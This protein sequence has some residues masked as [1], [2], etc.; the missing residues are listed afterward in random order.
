MAPFK[1]FAAK[2]SLAAQKK[3]GGFIPSLPRASIRKIFVSV[4]LRV[5]FGQS[6]QCE[7]NGLACGRGAEGFCNR[8]RVEGEIAA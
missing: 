2:C 4:F 8:A 1:V 6:R 7:I 5:D 3:P